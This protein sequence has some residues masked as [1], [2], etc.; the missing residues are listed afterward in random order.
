MLVF[1][2]FKEDF[3]VGDKTRWIVRVVLD[4]AL[5]NFQSLLEQTHFPIGFRQRRKDLGAWVAHQDQLVLFNRFIG[6]HVFIVTLACYFNKMIILGID[7]GT[8]V[9]GYGI[10]RKTV[11]GLEHVDH[12]HIKI[13]EK[14][15]F[16]PRLGLMSQRV[17]ELI[18]KI[19]PQV[20]VIEK[21]F[22]GKNVD[23]AFKL[24]HIRGV[25]IHEAHKTNAE[26]VEY[27]P[28]E[29]KKGIT[30]SGAAEKE[31]VQ[32]LLYAQL[33]IRDKK[34][35]DASDALAL[36]FHHASRMDLI[37]RLRGTGFEI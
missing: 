21:I 19:Q 14:I 25:C 4:A 12:G 11:K 36:A 5:A 13:A 22:L 34:S 20:M 33:N 30:G 29:V 18:Q 23:S 35:L 28:R 2:Q 32:V 1:F 8:Q 16:L 37:K 15:D 3:A 17:A 7:P 27:S 24:G 31:Q 9:L 10:I 26:I 6:K